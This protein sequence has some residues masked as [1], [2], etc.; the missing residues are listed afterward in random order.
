MRARRSTGEIPM[1]GSPRI[2]AS[3]GQ[4][5]LVDAALDALPVQREESRT[6]ERRIGLSSSPG[7]WEQAVAIFAKDL[8]AELRNRAAVTAILLF[9]VT[10]LVV[11]GFAVGIGKPSP[12]VKAALLWVVLFFAAFSGLA[13][14]FRSEEH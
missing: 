5:K 6:A 11:V 8:R 2:S 3:A 12:G 10:S 14:V 9:A 13:H 7:W 1:S 4:A